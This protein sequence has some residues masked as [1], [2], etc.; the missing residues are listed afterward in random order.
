[1]S[2]RARQL[3]ARVRTRLRSERGAATAEYAITT[4][5]AVGFAGLLVVILRSGE[6]RG[7][8]TDLVRNALSIPA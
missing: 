4:L 6:V 3:R 7:M 2:L 1:M 8:L 5:A